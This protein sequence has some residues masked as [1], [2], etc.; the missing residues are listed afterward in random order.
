MLLFSNDFIASRRLFLAL[1]LFTNLAVGDSPPDAVLTELDDKDEIESN[2]SSAGRMADDK[3]SVVEDGL[4]QE[5]IVVM[6]GN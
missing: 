1:E 2:E 6:A 4:K 5:K 3:A